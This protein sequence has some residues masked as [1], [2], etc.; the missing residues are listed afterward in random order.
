[1]IKQTIFRFLSIIAILLVV[2]SCGD[3]PETPSYPPGSTFKRTVMVYMAAQNT[4]GASGFA[5]QDSAE[6]ANG[7]R[8]LHAGERVLMF[9][10][11]NKPPRLYELRKGLSAPR[12]VKEWKEDVNSADPKTLT[13]LLTTMRTDFTSES[14]GLVLWSHATGWIPSPKSVAE[15]KN[16]VATTHNITAGAAEDL[17]SRAASSVQ[18]ASLLTRNDLWQPESTTTADNARASTTS[19]ENSTSRK[20]PAFSAKSYGMDVGKNGNWNADIAVLGAHPDEINIDDLGKAIAAANIPLRF[21]HMDCCLMGDIQSFYALRHSADY[22]AASPIEISA[23]G[24]FY[25]DMLRWGYFSEEIKDLGI[26]YANYYLGKGSEPYTDNFGL[27]FAIVR[28]DKLQAVAEAMAAELPQHLPALKADG[29]KNFPNMTETQTYARYSARKFWRPHYYDMN[30]ALR[31]SLP[32]ES[33]QRVK[34]ALDA[35]TVYKFTT[36]RFMTGLTVLYQGQYAADVIAVDE[37]NFCGISM[38]VPQETYTEHAVSNPP[39]WYRACPHGDF[40]EEFRKTE[41]YTAAGWKA[42]GW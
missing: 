39:S 31:R 5:R 13:E 28:S 22:I 37:A 8:Y 1:M 32:T 2:V 35:A 34:R 10:D 16:N 30:D 24:G 21:I 40:N 36:P 4:L 3:E 7:M 9:L 23:I 12:L 27:V 19:K 41:W 6:M 42:A 14:Y 11:D 18:N 25:T 33:W 29:S 20:K 26:T 17:A 15:E 38:F